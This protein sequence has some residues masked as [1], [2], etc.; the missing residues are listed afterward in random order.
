MKILNKKVKI[1]T[2]KGMDILVD[3]GYLGRERGLRKEETQFQIVLGRFLML[4][5]SLGLAFLLIA[6]L[7]LGEFLPLNMFEAGRTQDL[8][9]FVLSA[10]FLYSIF[11]LRDRNKFFDTL[12]LR[13]LSTLHDKL[14]REEQVREIELLDYVDVDVLDILDDLVASNEENIFPVLMEKLA[15]L[16][17]VQVLLQRLGL[18]PKEFISKCKN[19]PIVVE[20]DKTSLIN[21]AL[22]QAFVVGFNY[23]FSYIGEW[24]VFLELALDEYSGLF[25]DFG[26]QKET[27]IAVLEW[28]RS[29]AIVNKYKKVWKYRASLKPKNNLNRSMTSGF[30]ATLNQYSRD[31]TVEVAVGE[32]LYALSRENEIAEILRY[33]RQGERASV[34]LLGEPGVG[35]TTVL[36]SIATRMVVEDVPKDLRDRRLVEFDFQRAIAKSK[37]TAKLRDVIAKIFK[38]VEKAKNIILVIDDFDQLINMREE[39]AEEIVST[40]SRALETNKIKIIATSTKIGYRKSIKINPALANMFDNVEINEQPKEIA[41]QIVLD[42][43]SRFERRYGVRIQFDALQASV[44]LTSKYDTTR[45]LPQKAL[46]V[47]E[48]ACI[49]ALE[50]NLDFVAGST[51]EKIVSQDTGI[52]VGSLKKDESQLLLRLEE[53]MHRRI[54]GQDKAVSAVADALRRARAG[55]AGANRPVASF[56]FFGPTGVGKTEVAKTLAEIYFG[57]EDLLTRLDMSEYQETENVKRLIGF[58]EGNEFVGGAL[59]EKVREKPF[60]LVLLDEI[61][62]ANPKVLDLFLQVLDEGM[63][64]DGAG[65]KVDFRNTIIIATSNIGSR[66]IAAAIEAGNSYE[67]T[68]RI[69][70]VELKKALKIEFINRFDKVIMFKPLSQ[71]EI[72]KIA[73]IMMEKVVDKL[74]G[75][76]IDLKYGE[77]LLAELAKKGYSPVFGARELRRLIQDEVESKI[78]ELIVAGKLK[79]GESLKVEGLGSLK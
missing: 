39:V 20:S 55:L 26:I 13:A 62:K 71:V 30:T 60:S 64:T 6:D 47:I 1:G 61:E 50:E 10:V 51:V 38:E 68:Y 27:L 48:D 12:D 73:G 56:L 49:Y 69:A 5:A 79:S 15:G 23:G 24:V 78:A 76:G 25:R 75:Q 53:I 63:I 66:Q 35:K 21:K 32:F 33:L 8:V 57:K 43:R 11:L 59:T 19:Y 37:D 44:D 67:D 3:W 4:F 2:F 45:L 70:Q 41:L 72:E 42:E 14:D 7:S 34:L 58:M 17:D 52:G 18:E 65:R 46:D 9:A 31:L 29:Q 36:K 22:F 77:Q 28:T 40:I 16:R 74:N 54:V